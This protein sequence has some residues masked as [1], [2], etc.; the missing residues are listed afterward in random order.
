MFIIE[1]YLIEYLSNIYPYEDGSR[2]KIMST[3]YPT[4]SNKDESSSKEICLIIE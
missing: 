4:H 2:Q 1:E 3:G